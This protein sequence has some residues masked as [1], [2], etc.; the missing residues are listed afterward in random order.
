[1]SPP[2]Y[3]KGVVK[4]PSLGGFVHVYPVTSGYLCDVLLLNRPFINNKVQSF[5]TVSWFAILFVDIV[6]IMLMYFQTSFF[7]TVIGSYGFVSII[8]VKVNR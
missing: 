1:M 6:V 4:L 8:L 3:V 7:I 5:K 2:L